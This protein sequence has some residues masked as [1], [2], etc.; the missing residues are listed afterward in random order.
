MCLETCVKPHFVWSFEWKAMLRYAL[1]VVEMYMLFRS[2]C[3]QQELKSF[4]LITVD[5]KYGSF[6]LVYMGIDN[7]LFCIFSKVLFG[8]LNFLTD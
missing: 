1:F 3:G 6:F 7:V 5:K 2:L 4:A 8:I